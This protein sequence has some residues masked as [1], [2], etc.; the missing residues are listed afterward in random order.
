M[1]FWIW[2]LTPHKFEPPVIQYCMA[3]IDMISSRAF[4]CHLLA[5]SYSG[6]AGKINPVSISRLSASKLS[7]RPDAAVCV[8]RREFHFQTGSAHTGSEEQEKTNTTT[9]FDKIFRIYIKIRHFHKIFCGGWYIYIIR[10]YSLTLWAKLKA[11]CC[12]CGVGVA[13]ACVKSLW[14]GRDPGHSGRQL[15]GC[16]A[17]P[18]DMWPTAALLLLL[19]LNIP[20]ASAG[21]WSA[22]DD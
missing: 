20:A 18:R 22:E 6:I 17:L 15:G 11:R 19:V 7:R 14:W 16:P 2:E 5:F 4:S 21:K 10:K 3:Y 12:V 8:V 9:V 1:S 13:G